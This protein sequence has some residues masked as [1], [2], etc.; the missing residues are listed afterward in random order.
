M[1]FNFQNFFVRIFALP[2]KR[3]SAT[4]KIGKYFLVASPSPLLSCLR[5]CFRRGDIKSRKYIYMRC[6]I[7][8][9]FLLLKTQMWLSICQRDGATWVCWPENSGQQVPFRFTCVN[10]SQLPHS[11][12]AQS[13]LLIDLQSVKDEFKKKEGSGNWIRYVKFQ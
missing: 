3:G 1:I 2:W 13:A 9:K 12:R 7:T 10:M 8:Q 5:K 4:P 6:K 11:K